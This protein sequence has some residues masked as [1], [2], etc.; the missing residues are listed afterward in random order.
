MKKLLEIILLFYT[1][2]YSFAQPTAGTTGL[3]N[4]PSAEMPLDGTF[5]AGA[6]Y[7]PDNVTHQP[8]FN[9]NTFNYYVGMAFLPFMELSFRMILFR[10]SEN[11]SLRN[12]DRSLALRVRV[13]NERK[14][15]PSVVIGGNDV[16]TTSSSGNQYFRS[17]YIACTKTFSIDGYLTGVSLGYAPGNLS[18]SNI[19][20]LFGGISF[21]PAFFR[22]FT[23]IA[24]YD[25]KYLDAGA[26][27]LLFRH[28]YLYGFASDLKQFAGGIAFRLYPKG[29]RT[30]ASF[31]SSPHSDTD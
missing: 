2:C 5:T 24:D 20:G 15:L 7:L 4:C 28:F 1:G 6:N 10:D 14:F 9:Y 12:Q 29:T 30:E 16:Y 11:G 17:L 23:I 22:S 25:T 3:L 31:L 26:S 18:N 19:Y 13:L 27:L 8:K 21:S